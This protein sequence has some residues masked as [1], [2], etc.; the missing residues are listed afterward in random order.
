[1]LGAIFPFGCCIRQ[2][3]YIDESHVKLGWIKIQKVRFLYRRSHNYMIRT[4]EYKNF[5]LH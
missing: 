1:M 3:T 2:H 5:S 4:V